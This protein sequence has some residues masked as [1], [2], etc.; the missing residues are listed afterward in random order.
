M[1]FEYMKKQKNKKGFSLVEI[2]LSVFLLS[3]GLTATAKLMLSGYKNSIDSRNAIVAS[4]LV[5]EGLEIVRNFRD[6]N[7]AIGRAAFNGLTTNASY[8]CPILGINVAT[9]AN[10]STTSALMRC[11]AAND[12][13][14]YFQNGDGGRGFSYSSAGAVNTVF[15][16][17][18][19]LD[20]GDP[21]RVRS[22]VIWGNTTF[23]S[24]EADI[25]TCTVKNKCV[26][27]D[28]LLNSTGWQ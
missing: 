14:L 20:S 1:I 9:I 13:R 27:A 24:V 21:R 5:Q 7:I 26:Y 3:L 22:I 15:K 6:N 8:A 19:T 23:A 10:G 16:R 11:A 25:S 18:V 2:L 28:L 17:K 12:H 4:E